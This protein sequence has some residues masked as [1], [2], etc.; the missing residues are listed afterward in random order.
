MNDNKI[1]CYNLAY[2]FI[3]NGYKREILFALEY[4]Q[5]FIKIGV[6]PKPLLSLS[7]EEKT[8]NNEKI[9]S[10]ISEIFETNNIP[11]TLKNFRQ[12]IEKEIRS[13][14]GLESDYNNYEEI[15][16]RKVNFINNNLN[17]LQKRTI[18]NMSKNIHQ[19]ILK[20]VQNIFNVEIVIENGKMM[21]KENPSTKGA[22]LKAGASLLLS[23][24]GTAAAYYIGAMAGEQLATG[25]FLTLV[26]GIQPGFSIFL[27]DETIFAAC[28]PC[29]CSL[30]VFTLGIGAAIGGI[31]LTLYYMEE[32]KKKAYTISIK[33]MEEKF[34]CV[35]DGYEKKIIREYNAKREKTCEEIASYLNM[36][37][38]PVQ[39][40]DD[41]KQSLFSQYDYLKNDIMNIIQA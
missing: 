10:E 40:N 41:Q 23:G 11:E 24:A 33:N 12:T 3:T 7:E 14:S 34:F 30:G 5:N 15:I 8:K 28:A 31:C 19:G 18:P 21:V 22:Y 25:L 20:V 39:L 13:D 38:N 29:F 37:Y 26:I 1:K 9:I 6:I 17:K 16:K 36:C 27:L 35:F 2:E 32:R 4:I